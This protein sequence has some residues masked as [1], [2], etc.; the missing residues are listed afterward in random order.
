MELACVIFFLVK[1]ERELFDEFDVICKEDTLWIEHWKEKE[2][3]QKG[4]SP[5]SLSAGSA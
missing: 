2:V 3:G 1:W 4:H 5:L